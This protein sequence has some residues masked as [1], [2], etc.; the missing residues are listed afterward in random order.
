MKSTPE[1]LCRQHQDTHILLV[2]VVSGEAHYL[3]A[4]H[5][6]RMSQ[7]HPHKYSVSISCVAEPCNYETTTSLTAAGATAY[8]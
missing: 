8:L 4:C 5:Q 3:E 6:G 1:G 7:K 2:R